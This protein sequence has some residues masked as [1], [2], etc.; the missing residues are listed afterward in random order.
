MQKKWWFI[1]GL[2]VLIFLGSIFTFWSIKSNKK[3]AELSSGKDMSTS[4][5]K[6]ESTWEDPLGFSFKYDSRLKVDKHDEDQENYAHVE[7]THLQNP[8]RII[9]WA[10]DLPLTKSLSNPINLADWVKDNAE[11]KNAGVLE[12]T[13]GG[14][15]AKKI[16]LTDAAQ[17]QF[18]VTFY[19]DLLYLIESDFTINKF[20]EEEFTD[21]AQSFS[22]GQSETEKSTSGFSENSAS[23]EEIV[24]EEE[25][26]E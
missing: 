21:I 11:F 18:I 23:Y 6:N 17:K 1:I 19:D 13:L 20:W 26:V 16:L 2:A 12:T 7:L 4:S 3:T 14:I 8:G 5:A 10:K 25:V 9:V 24:D 22:F 15:E